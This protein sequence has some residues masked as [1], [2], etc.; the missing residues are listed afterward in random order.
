MTNLPWKKKNK[1]LLD[2]NVTV[3]LTKLESAISKND[4]FQNYGKGFYL[5]K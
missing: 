1:A 5:K 2:D 3:M 4:R